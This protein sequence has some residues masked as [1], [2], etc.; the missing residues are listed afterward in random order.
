[1]HHTPQITE[2]EIQAFQENG[3]FQLKQCLSLELVNALRLALDRVCAKTDRFHD[4]VTGTTTDGTQYIS[5]VDALLLKEEPVFLALLGSPLLLAV[6]EAV[7]GEEFFPVQEFA[8]I[9]RKGDPAMINW[10]QDV[11]S[12]AIGTTCMVGLYLDPADADNGALRIVPGSQHLGTDICNLQHLPSITADMQAGDVLVHDLMVAHC[13]GPLHTQTQRRVVYFEFMN[14]ACALRDNV[15]P[16]SFLKAR[17]E[18]LDIG[19]C[20]Y[21]AMTSGG[22]PHS[23][24]LTA[25]DDLQRISNHNRAVK[26]ANYCFDLN[27]SMSGTMARM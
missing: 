13:S 25:Q 18:L 20:V 26:P 27:A 5:G 12:H 4:L 16:E 7:C 17:M 19:K 8:V 14:T 1:M 6:A 10:H 9:K 2:K 11:V 22:D 15:Y 24:Y 3:Y 21:Q 23:V